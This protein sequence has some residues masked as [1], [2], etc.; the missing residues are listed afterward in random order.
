MAELDLLKA[1]VQP[2]FVF[3]T[4]NNIYYEAYVEAPRTAAL[5]EQ[6]A[7]IMRY[8]VDESPKALVP[9]ATEIGFIENYIALE[10]IRMRHAVDCELTIAAGKSLLLPPMLLMTFIE[11]IFKH[12]IDKTSLENK[13]IIEMEEKDRLLIFRTENA[14]RSNSDHVP[15]GG[16][17]L[18]NLRSRLQLLYQDNFELTT[19][20]K[21]QLFIATLKIPV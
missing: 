9:L 10:Q 17:G 13:I 14:F 16:F 3:N 6:L 8:F 11:N 5:I 2:H 1:Q 20:V 19:S 4:L 7:G 12:G 18:A 15:S 21:D